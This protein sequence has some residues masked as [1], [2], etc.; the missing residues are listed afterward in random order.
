SFDVEAYDVDGASLLQPVDI[1]TAVYPF[2][3]P[4]RTADDVEHA[5]GALEKAYHDR[6]YQ[7]V[8]VEVPAQN[9]GEIIRLHVVEAPVGRLRVVGSRYFSPEVIRRLTPSLKEGEVPDF[10]HTQKELA[11]TN[12]LSDRRVTP[13][14]RAGV[15]P[16]TVDVD[17]KV[18]D[19]LPAHASLELTN[20]HSQDTKPLRL[21]ASAH[22]DNLWQL[23]HSVSFTYSVAPQ[24]PSDSQIFAGSYLAPLWGTPWS[25]LAYGYDSNSNVATLGGTNVL[26]K[27]Y[28]LGLRGIRQLP[29]LADFSQSLSFGPDFKHFDENISF[30]GP[31]QADNVVYVPF[32]AVYSLQRADDRSSERGSLG[33]TAGIRGLGSDIAAFQFKRGDA[34]PNFIHLNLDMALTQALGHGVE[35]AERFSGQLADQPLIPSEEFAAGGLA[36][37]RGYLQSEAIGDSGFSG[38]LE[39]RSPALAPRLG[40][41]AD[42]F[43]E[44]LRVYGFVDGA[45]L[46]VIDP[47]PEQTDVFAL[48]SAGLGVRFQVLKYLRGDLVLALPLVDGAVTK[49]GQ[50]RAV[51]SVKSEF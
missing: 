39:L 32:N 11:E 25:L 7:S 1:E 6:G 21:I 40:R 31:V 20:D 15:A 34:N 43:V 37:V 28:A 46:R 49:M 27:G 16:G 18:S 4:G 13:V 12:R 45:F 48:Y 50:P 24:R 8:V 47:L 44:D 35:A 14:L 23:G 19:T 3:G 2:L 51:F 36:S 5:R 38:S 9:P 33:V 17:L 22:Y 41:L 10:N 42:R 30:G 26:G 29:R